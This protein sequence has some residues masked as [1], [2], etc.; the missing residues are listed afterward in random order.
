MNPIYPP[1]LVEGEIHIWLAELDCPPSLHKEIAQSLSQEEKDR[2]IR[3]IDSHR[4]ARFVVG[5]GFLR[6]LLGAYL[7]KRPHEIQFLCG[8]QGKPYLEYSKNEKVRFNLSHSGKYALYAFAS[9][10]EVGVDIEEISAIDNLESIS[11][12]YFSPQENQVIRA[13]PPQE[14]VN[15]FFDC[16]TRKEA[17]IKACGD[18]FAIPLDSFTVSLNPG[19]SHPVIESGSAYFPQADWRILPLT[20]TQGYTGAVAVQGPHNLHQFILPP[21]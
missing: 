18:G 13:L 19:E 14:Q 16:W 15:A 17:L 11:R 9:G 1:P 4:R 8:P 2:A 6:S 5:R 7:S 3:F 20:P 10:V 21:Q 12:R